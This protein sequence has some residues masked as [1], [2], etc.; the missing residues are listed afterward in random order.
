[1]YRIL[2]T[3]KSGLTAFQKQLD[4]ISNNISNTQTEGYKQLKVR[5][6]SLLADSIK[7]NGVPLSDE[8]RNQDAR[9][10]T[11]TMTTESYRDNE[12]GVI[13]K[14][15][16]PLALAIQGEGYFGI[17]DDAGNQF[18]TRNGQF[19]L[20][21]EGQ[22]MDFNGNSLDVDYKRDEFDQDQDI[23]ITEEGLI[24]QRN[25][26]GAEREMGRI[27]LYEVESYN[28]LIENGNGYLT[29]DE[30]TEIDL[31]KSETLIKQGY[32]EKSNVDIGKELVQMMMTQRAYELNT[33]TLKA[34]DEMW[35]LA[36]N[37]R[38]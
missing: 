14:D 37:L 27:K 3:G 20:S 31:T 13:V 7:N 21:E 4:L 33:R 17:V 10:G 2:S 12:Q 9:I 1:M 24:I 19:T 28:L 16:N 25:S 5:F 35:S 8:L 26:L 34:A 32:I 6:E 38:R 36:N 18:L 29:S 23:E 30:I 22:L 15:I 11:G